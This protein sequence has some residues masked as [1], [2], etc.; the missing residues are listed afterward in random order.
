[1]CG[2][3]GLSARNELKTEKLHNL[4]QALRHRGP[5]G[6]GI[7]HTNT[8]GL[9]HTRLS[10]VDLTTGGQPLHGAMDTVLVA[11]GE[12]YNNPQLRLD[13]GN[14]RFKTHS[15]CE[16]I[17]ALWEKYGMDTPKH[18]RGMFAFALYE[19]REEALYLSRDPFGIK[20]LYYLCT[21]EGF[22]F[23]SEPM[24]LVHAKFCAAHIN[25]QALTQLLQ[26][27]YTTGEDT[28]FSGIKRVLP[29]QTLKVVKG[30]IVDR[31]Q[32]RPLDLST[33]RFFAQQEKTSL[34]LK[35]ILP[36]LHEHLRESVKVHLQ[37]DV[38]YGLFLSGGIDSSIVLSHMAQLCPPENL[39]TYSIGF[40]DSQLHDE[41]HV[42]RKMAESVKALHTDVDFHE[43]D[44]WHLLPQVAKALDDPVIDYAALPTFK[45]AQVAA[46]NV[47]VVLCGEGGDEAFA[48]YRRHQRAQRP[49][50]LGG[51]LWRGKG[52]FTEVPGVIVDLKGWNNV[53]NA[54][55]QQVKSKNWSRVQMSQYIDFQH[56]L[57]DDLLTKLD[58]CLMACGVEGRTPFVDRDVSLY[59]FQL[60]DGYKVSLMEGKIILR[61]YLARYFPI[62][63][64]F[65]KKRGFTVPVGEWITLRSA[66]VARWLLK[67]EGVKELLTPVAINNLFTSLSQNKNL[68]LPAWSLLFYAVWH[69]IHL[70]G[71]TP[72]AEEILTS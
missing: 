71:R 17:L 19:P 58:R 36:N 33:P 47:K 44:F 65:A 2:I 15:D 27:R 14:Y 37:S 46:Q 25:P 1:M 61:E 56:W 39:R 30:N 10:I 38:P 35:K 43:S 55:Q 7:Y 62:S 54:T 24:A 9:V 13:M 45:L 50:L 11:N 34:S 59:G 23:A 18:L 42:A 12:I 52:L 8:V 5:D 49:R 66:S 68:T 41:R 16:P 4:A 6:Q 57:P 20:P 67:Q 32:W 63:E 64:P 22:S 53:L 40:P 51:R 48:G 69:E 60:P 31:R 72:T 28:I 26:L 3:A 21:E 29:G 70:V